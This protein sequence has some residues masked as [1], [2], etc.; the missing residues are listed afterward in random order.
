MKKIQ[1]VKKS[2]LAIGAMIALAPAVMSC[3]EKESH[4][5]EG[6]HAFVV[7]VV[8]DT[9]NFGSDELP[10]KFPTAF[11]SNGSCPADEVCYGVRVG[12]YAVD[13]EGN[14]LPNYT[15]RVA[16]TAA[17]GKL[18]KAEVWFENG[19]FGNW[20]RD[21]AGQPVSLIQGEPVQMR[22]THGKVRLWVEDSIRVKRTESVDEFCSQ[23][24][25][26]ISE[27][28]IYCEPTYA[29]G[30]SE[31]FVFEPQTIKMIQYNPDLP[32]GDSALLHNYGQI[33]AL[34]G[35]DIVVTN[36]VSSG[37]YITDLG[38]EDYN[39]LFI[40][41]FSQPGRVEIG[42]RVCEVSGGVSEFTGMTQLQFPSWGLQGKERSTAEDIDPA[43][44][45][46]DQG[47]G[48]CVDKETGE[49]RP[50]TDEDLQAMAELVDCY[51]VYNGNK[52]ETE[53]EKR[54]NKKAF[55]T[56][57]PP[58]P[59]VLST[60]MLTKENV[61]AL[62][63]LEAAVVTI[64]DIRLS[65]EFINC[66][67]NGNSKIETGTAEADCRTNCTNSTLC[68]E[69]SNLESYDQWRAWTIEGNA[70]VSVASSA[71]IAGFNILNECQS[72]VD[73]TTARVMW[74]CPER[75]LKRL[76]GNL[77]QV[78]PGCA[79]RP[80]CNAEDFRMAMIMSVIEPR[81]STDLIMDEAFNTA[82]KAAF[83][84]CWADDQVNGCRDACKLSGHW[85][86][87]DDFAEYRKDYGI[88]GQ[89][90]A[91]AGKTPAP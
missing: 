8:P 61:N 4:H 22:F 91:C 34:P 12:A 83:D 67:D 48:S 70:D 9:G 35:H 79:G 72:W 85:C 69:L 16:L 36:V 18:D 89:P 88:E 44:E 46:G 23:N 37:F 1:L 20:Q 56:L 78:L 64:Q 59:R 57:E 25:F 86:T 77:K 26:K 3:V 24:N 82:S 42:D 41:T 2:C 32:A 90:M 80:V 75:R 87:C 63:R 27:D 29:T 17:P 71:L 7:K 52:V 38:D 10:L 53:E 33:N 19:V 54:A 43:P 5:V 55:A 68:T 40:F 66:D 74:R 62:E 65:T 39:S 58:E 21:A 51:D 81:F 14:F 50:C 84:E 28:G 31:E 76:T 13:I 15:G 73:P 6:V 11:A 49:T 30:V 60:A 47:V 45:D